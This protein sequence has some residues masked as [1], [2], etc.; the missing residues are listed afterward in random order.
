VLL[1]FLDPVTGQFTLAGT[2]IT[3]LDSAAVRS[4]IGLD[5]E[6]ADALTADLLTATAGR[7][8]LL[9]T[10]RR[11]PASQVDQVLQLRDGRLT[12]ANPAN[13][14]AGPV[15]DADRRPVPAAR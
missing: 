8:V 11:V 6:T 14:A 2:D 3:E 4:V 12:Q 7:T 15:R 1:R 9:I 5:E 10:H 13:P